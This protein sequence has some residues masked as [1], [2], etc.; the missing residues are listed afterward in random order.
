MCLDCQGLGYI[1]GSNLESNDAVLSST[2]EEVLF[3]LL[4]GSSHLENLIIDFFEYFEIDPF[5]PLE[6]LPKKQRDFFFYGDP[7]K[8]Y[9]LKKEKCYLIWQGVNPILAKAAK[10]GAFPYRYYL[11]PMMSHQLCPT[12]KGARL[13]DLAQNVLI[14]DLSIVDLTNLSIDKTKQFVSSL[15]IKD[16]PFLRDS[17]DQLHHHLSFMQQIGLG[18]LSLARSAPTL[19]GGEMQR[20]RLAR[21]LGSTLSSCIYIL[22][23]P[24]IGLHPH[25]S[26]LLIKTLRKLMSW[27][28]SL[29]LVEHDPQILKHADLIYDFGP[30]AGEKGGKIVAI[31][32]PK[33]IQKNP[34]SLTG[35]YMSGKKKIPLPETRRKPDTFFKIKKAKLHNLKGVNVS[36]PI[37]AISCVTGVSGSGK[38]TLIHDILRPQ[39][40]DFLRKKTPPKNIVGYEHFDQIIMLDQTPIS[41][42]IR[43][44]VSTYSTIMPLIRSFYASLKLSK[45]KGLMPRHFSYNHKRGMCRTCYGL[46]YKT[47]DLQFLPP[48]KILCDS[49]HG[50]RLNP[51][52]LSITYKNKNLGQ[53]LKLSVDKAID[54]FSAIPRIFKRLQMLSNVGLGYVKLGQDIG[55]LSG[56]EGQRLRLGKELSKRQTGKTLYLFDEPSIGLH[57]DDI[58]KLLPIFQKLADKKNTLIIIEHNIDIIKNADYIVDMG[59]EAGDKGGKVIF[60]GSLDKMQD[61][62]D[63]F[64]AKYLFTKSRKSSM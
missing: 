19:S 30:A 9:Y 27:G 48:V 35:A 20:L 5:I 49:C 54:F 13:N 40:Q 32:T 24:T 8:K 23:E 4:E 56:G 1:Y 14:K 25:N 7:E 31:G 53:V 3:E 11:V 46:G 41:Q 29:I 21:Q 36:F 64:T 37:G 22:D 38:S 10:H 59:P 63:S 18:Y 61:C 26:H 50:Y 47:V 52:S 42:T 58:A 60:Q 2:I 45:A 15:S 12:C 57:S 62:K 39:I 6:D 51:V 28:N 34:H 43:S 17:F 16:K 44:D 55:S 33:E